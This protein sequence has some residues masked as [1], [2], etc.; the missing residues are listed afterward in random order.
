[1]TS[2]GTCSS[3]LLENIASTLASARPLVWRRPAPVGDDAAAEFAEVER[4]RGGIGEPR[5]AGA[6]RF[7]VDRGGRRDDV[8]HATEAFDAGAQ[9]VG[10]EM[11]VEIERGDARR[12]GEMQGEREG[13][14]PAAADLEQ[15]PAGHRHRGI[16]QMADHDAP[17][18][19]LAVELAGKVAEA[20]K[21]RCRT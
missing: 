18:L 9:Q 20:P 7:P 13:R 12:A 5:M 21:R 3:T 17:V 10:L 4:A 19:D 6:N 11:A 16:A 14:I 2:A 15:V 1:M 8:E